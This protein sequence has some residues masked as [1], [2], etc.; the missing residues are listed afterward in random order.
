MRDLLLSFGVDRWV[1]PALLVWPIIAA[2][3][4][5]LL[6]RDQS[7][8]DAG[9]EAPS[10][11]PDARVL[12]LGALIVEALMAVALWGVFATEKRGWQARFDA[13]WL[14]D[15]GAT[16]SLGVDGLSMPLVVVSAVLLPLVFLGAWDNVRVRTPAFGALLLLLTSGVIGVFVA[17]DLLLFYLAW[18]LMLIPTYLLVGIWSVEGTARASLRYVLYTLVGSLL[19]LVALLAL[20]L[21]GG[22]NNFHY[23]HLTLVLLSPRT[24]LAMLLAFF[25]AFAVKSALVPFHNWFPDAQR[26]APTVAA[27]TIGLKVGAY[28]LIRFALPLFPAA[29]AYPPVRNT[30][31]VLSVVAILYGAI[32]AMA[33]RDL[34]RLISYSAISHFGF[35]LLG[36]FALTPEGMQGAAMSIINSALT[37]GALLLLAGA[38]EDRTGS[39]ELASY[40]GLAK[41]APWFALAMTVAMLA[42]IGLPGTSGFVAE[43]IV[44]F[45]AFMTK[46]YLTLVA[47]LGV[48]L[49]AVYG[50]RGLQGVLYGK[51]SDASQLVTDLTRRER[52]V[53]AVLSV[54]IIALGVAPAPVLRPLQ[55]GT[56]SMLEAVQF[57]PNAPIAIPTM[58]KAP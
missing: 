23:D 31:L 10:G 29:V 22:G 27:V 41:H 36:T 2:V 33:Q 28:G 39:T 35:I 17:I 24:Q 54:A 20:W 42:T 38:L 26:A 51:T 34:K 44:L 58:S 4:V 50:L 40:G 8:N 6:G 48:I 13:P 14:A 55:R 7:R 53:L 47:A 45:G 9:L 43:W 30:I 46:P 56:T 32:M 15:L 49:A 18:E 3:M 11:G 1:L 52:L 5:R 19:M 12:T 25:L 21:I 16:I 57:G 37:T